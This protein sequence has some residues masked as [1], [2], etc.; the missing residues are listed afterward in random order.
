MV[1]LTVFTYL[2]LRDRFLEYILGCDTVMY[3]KYNCFASF[4]KSGVGRRYQTF[5]MCLYSGLF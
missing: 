2:E 1:T 3:C 4:V 5:G